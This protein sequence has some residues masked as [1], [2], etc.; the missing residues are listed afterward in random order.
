MEPHQLTKADAR[1]IAIQ[2]QL[3]DEPRPTD[4]LE[5][6]RHLALVQLNPT[7]A[8]RAERGSAAVEPDR[9]VVLAGR[10]DH[11]RRRGPVDRVQDDGSAE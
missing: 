9:V 3:L 11:A 8:D 1:R 4:V 5:V 10:P 2:A 7:N 6:V